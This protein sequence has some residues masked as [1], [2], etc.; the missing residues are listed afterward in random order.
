MPC[1]LDIPG[2]ACPFLKGNRESMDQGKGGWGF[3]EKREGSLSQ[4][5]IYE[6]NIRK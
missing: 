6:R 3:R 2:E 5:V 4:K 1:L